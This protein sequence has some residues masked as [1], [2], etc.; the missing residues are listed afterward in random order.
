MRLHAQTFSDAPGA[1]TRPGLLPF[2]RLLI[3]GTV[4]CTLLGFFGAGWW[5][6]HVG[7]G[8]SWDQ[9]NYHHYN[10]YS[11]LHDRMDEHLAP[12]GMQSWINPLAYLPAYV[13]VNHLPPW[14]TGFTFGAVAGLNFGL[15]FALGCLLLRREVVNSSPLL[16]AGVALT[17]ALVGLSDP[18]FHSNLGTSDADVFLSLFILGSLCL[19]CWASDIS[20]DEGDVY[21]TQR[22]WGFAAAAALLGAAAGL[23]LTYFVQVVAMTATLILLWRS[24]GLTFRRFSLFAAGGVGGYALT[25][26]YWNLLLWS[27]YGNPFLPYWNNMFHS[28]WLV[29]SNFRDTRFPTGSW[30]GLLNFPFAWLRGEHPTSEA[31]FRIAIFAIL[32]IIIPIVAAMAL[33]RRTRR[34]S[35]EKPGIP[36]ARPESLSLTAR[37]ATQFVMLFGILSYGLWAW[38]FAI[39]RYLEATAL[40]AG[41]LLWMCCDYLIPRRWLK[42]AAYFSLSLFSV[43]W[44]Q[45]EK[46]DWR[47]PYG[48]S[49]FGVQLPAELEQ[50]HTMFIAIG[51]EPIA[52]LTPYLPASDTMVRMNELTIPMDGSATILVQRAALMIARHRGPMRSLTAGT[53]DDHGHYYL[54][55]YGLSLVEAGCVQFSAAASQ[56]TSCPI[57][58]MVAA[59]DFPHP[60][61]LPR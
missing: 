21:S 50:H 24:L 35:Q 51:G 16:V 9:M 30:S 37:A 11:W 58:R 20:S 29:A 55:R 26:A 57:A 40:L 52:Y 33:V 1:K 17:A 56:F 15:L 61:P 13:M 44:M 19:I 28:R 53:I 27:R 6:L 3:Y 59:P 46:Q 25:G 22:D 23:K 32:E 14:L 18:F 12:A 36:V 38:M 42:L 60:S 2:P 7:K 8:I 49:W 34:W 47:V 10:V 5:T 54:A 4:L 31:P 41:Y 43:L 45:G 48:D 39:Q